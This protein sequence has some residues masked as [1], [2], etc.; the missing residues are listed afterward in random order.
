[1]R[2]VTLFLALLIVS[3]VSLIV[4]IVAGFY[5]FTAAQQSP[6]SWMSGMF[7]EGGMMNG[8]SQVPV[9]NSALPV[10]GAS[11]VVLIGVAVAGVVGMAYYVA[12]P[13]IRNR[14]ETVTAATVMQT[15]VEVK[16]LENPCT[17]YESVMKTLSDDERKIVTVLSVHDGK[18]LQK[19]IRS[20]T[21]MSRLR[22]HRI[23]ARMAERGIV[24]LEKTGNTNQV[25]LADWLKQ[26]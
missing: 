6:A 3:L 26:K 4:L 19:Y 21:G 7:G 14:A 16:A 10:F 24:T 11:F 5:V 20:E 23:V 9:Q 25:L 18:Y 15:G 12:L 22:T 1:M 13:E 8:N 2:R 17:P